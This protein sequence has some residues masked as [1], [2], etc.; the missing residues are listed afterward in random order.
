MFF[1]YITNIENDKIVILV[2]PK[3]VS[4]QNELLRYDLIVDSRLIKV[5]IIHSHVAWKSTKLTSTMQP[6]QQRAL[7]LWFFWKILF[8]FINEGLRL[9]LVFLCLYKN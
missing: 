5:E 4:L 6:A 8:S 9:L 7:I 2:Y 1:L 3:N